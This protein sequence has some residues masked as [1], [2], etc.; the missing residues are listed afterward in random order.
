MNGL[1]SLEL[2]NLFLNHVKIIGL[3]GG[4]LSAG[5][6]GPISTYQTL[7]DVPM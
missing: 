7:D 4:R 1:P 2:I 5:G 6:F 3:H